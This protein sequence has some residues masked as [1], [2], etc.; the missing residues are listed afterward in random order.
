RIV[1]HGAVVD[2]Q[3]VVGKDSTTVTDYLKKMVKADPNNLIPTYRATD[4]RQHPVVVDA[5]AGAGRDVRSPANI[6]ANGAVID[7][8]RAR[9]VDAA[10][11]GRRKAILDRQPGEGDSPGGNCDDRAGPSTINDCRPGTGANNLQTNTN[12][13]ILPVGRGC[14]FDGIT[15]SHKRDGM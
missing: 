5:A 10:A 7:R 9:V 15:R 14:D 6:P 1:A 11:R 12:S 2:R 3:D 8:K 4:N 13:E